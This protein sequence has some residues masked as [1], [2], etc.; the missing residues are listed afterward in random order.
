[1]ALGMTLAL[2]SCTS[3]ELDSSA[4]FAT[5]RGAP[6]SMVGRQHLVFPN[7]RQTDFVQGIDGAP[8][9]L[10]E[11]PLMTS[12]M[13]SAVMSGPI[14]LYRLA[15][16]PAQDRYEGGNFAFYITTNAVLYNYVDE[17]I[18]RRTLTTHVVVRRP[19]DGGV[20]SVIDLPG[21]YD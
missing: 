8:W 5:L 18:K 1:C 10:L 4:P 17:N 16:P 12:S 7:K 9:I 3:L 6:P 11:S 19:G 13:P 20:K 15:D 14:D 21:V 2:T